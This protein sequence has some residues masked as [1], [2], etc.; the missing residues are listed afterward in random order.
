MFVYGAASG[1]S[2][3]LLQAE[4]IHANWDVNRKIACLS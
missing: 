2:I 3:L 1:L 4:A